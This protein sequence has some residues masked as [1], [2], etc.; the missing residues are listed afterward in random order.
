MNFCTAVFIIFSLILLHYYWELSDLQIDAN[1][2]FD[3]NELAMD[4]IYIFLVYV[5]CLKFY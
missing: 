2:R 5:L 1:I 3:Q 4:R